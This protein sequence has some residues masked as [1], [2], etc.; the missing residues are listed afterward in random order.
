[1]TFDDVYS[2]IC[3]TGTHPALRLV[4]FRPFLEAVEQ[5]LGAGDNAPYT[6]DTFERALVIR[7]AYRDAPV[8]VNKIG[9]LARKFGLTSAGER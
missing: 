9:A 3:D 5:E 2:A 8:L 6:V 4:D 7:V 1:V